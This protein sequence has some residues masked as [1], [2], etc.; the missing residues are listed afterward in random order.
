VIHCHHYCSIEDL[1]RRNEEWNTLVLQQE[2]DT[3]AHK[4]HHQASRNAYRVMNN[5]QLME[6]H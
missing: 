6:R 4:Q 1:E 2:V 3:D 5:P